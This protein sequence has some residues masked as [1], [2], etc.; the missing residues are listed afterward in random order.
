MRTRR[1]FLGAALLVSGGAVLFGERGWAGVVP[2]GRV[3][4]GTR[5]HRLERASGGR[6]GVF[7]VD[8]GTGRDW[9]WRA[10]ERF[11]MCSTYKLLL[12]GAVLAGVD[13][14][15]DR[16]GRLVRFDA[17]QL[18]AY[19]PVTRQHIAGGM[20]VEALCAAAITVSDNRAANLLLDGLGGPKVV[21]EF[22]RRLGDAKT[23][24]DRNEP[25]VNECLPGDPR[26]TTTPA[27]MAHVLRALV[28][29]DAL[30]PASRALLT[31]WLVADRTGAKRIHAG[32]PESWREG[33]KTGSGERGTTNDVAILWPPKGKPV[34]VAAYLTG[35]PVSREQREA[36]LAAVGREVARVVERG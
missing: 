6:L 31:Q 32:V 7:C 17:R 13:R 36:T 33:D 20:T 5:I 12:V 14:G 26:D 23:R 4:F 19:S 8:T 35:A 22:A 25:D 16:L 9:G 27:G 34:L 2:P 21:T 24:L 18:V 28:L 11:P 30:R 10:Y 1:E 29:G 3:A 15:R